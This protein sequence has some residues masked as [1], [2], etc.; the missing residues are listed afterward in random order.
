M[1]PRL[2]FI[3]Y[4]Y[5]SVR[6]DRDHG[7][8]EGCIT[9]IKRGVP[10]KVVGIGK[11]QEYVVVEV[12]AGK[13]KL[14]IIN[15]YNPCK[16]LESNELEKVEGQDNENVIWCGDFNAHSTLWGGSRTDRNGQ[17]IEDML[18]DKNL[19]CL[20]NGTK[21]RIEVRNG[22]ESVLDLTLV[23]SRL[24]PKCVWEVYNKGTIGSDHYPVMSKLNIDITKHSEYGSCRWVF[25]KANWERFK[26]LSDSCLNLVQEDDIDKYENEVRQSIFLAAMATIPKSTGKGMR[27][28]VPWWDEACSKAIKVRNQAFKML[29]RTH[30]FQRL[31]EYKRA[32][33]VVRRTIRQTKRTYWREYCSFIGNMVS[34]DQVLGDDQENGRQ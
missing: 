7:N 28:A 21:T 17:V 14:V 6:R 2:D 34:V 19:V 4:D 5:I 33:A 24:A 29:K 15:F 10:Y 13:M 30:T 20:N 8:G 3:L 18:N 16:Q 11:D 1:K 27:K 22:K 26:E 23:S 9:F 31:I 32:Q 25:Q 12:W